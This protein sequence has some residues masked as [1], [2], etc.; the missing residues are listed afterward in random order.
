[1][2]VLEHTVNSQIQAGQI[3]ESPRK[4]AR[5]HSTK[6]H[7]HVTRKARVAGVSWYQGLW[8]P[9]SQEDDPGLLLTLPCPGVTAGSVGFPSLRQYSGGGQDSGTLWIHEQN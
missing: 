3:L 8:V 9:R 2:P 5:K 4:P 1:M 6:P 7:P